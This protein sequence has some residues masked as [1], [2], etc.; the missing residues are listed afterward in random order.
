M[1]EISE[2]GVLSRLEII[3]EEERGGKT[4]RESEV[5]WPTW[6]ALLARCVGI[7]NAT[8]ADIEARRRS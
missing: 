5:G 7:I 1:A 3:A 6:I 4:S 2:S 8:E